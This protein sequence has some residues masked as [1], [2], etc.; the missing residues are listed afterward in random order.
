VVDAFDDAAE[1]IG[2][3]IRPSRDPWLEDLEKVNA[4]S[5]GTNFDPISRGGGNRRG[6]NK[7]ARSTNEVGTTGE[8]RSPGPD[9][10]MGRSDAPP[11][12]QPDHR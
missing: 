2:T 3:T 8:L 7:M 11:S 12:G 4:R 1:S 10:H 5:T 9:P 6:K